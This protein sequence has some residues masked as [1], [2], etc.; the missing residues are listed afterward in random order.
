[1]TIP[2]VL[3]FGACAMGG[4]AIVAR[5]LAAWLPTVGMLDAPATG[6]QDRSV[7]RG[8]GV[9]IVAPVLLLGCLLLPNDP[10]SRQRIVV[11]VTAAG[12]I[13]IVS[14]IDDIR[15]IAVSIRLATH[16]ALA[17]ATIATVGPIR[18]ISAGPLGTLPLGAAAWPLSMLWIVGLTNAFNF[19]DG[20]DAMAGITAAVAGGAVAV[21]SW[22]V[23]EPRV[24]AVAIV[25]A[26]AC[27]GFLTVNWPPARIFMGDVGST[28]CGFLLAT[29]PMMATAGGEP[30]LALIVLLTTSPFLLDTA[31]TLSRRISHGE[32]IFQSHRTH[33]YQQLVLAGWPQA[34]VS[35][36]YG[37]LAAAAGAF[38]IYMTL[39]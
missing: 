35:C 27:L 7:P 6:F 22:L 16:V 2:G 18:E 4:A 37:G 13:A 23:G 19:M 1:M 3:L 11:P 5:A 29:L 30:R 12:G 25:F 39:R 31:L 26:A 20:I 33:I 17:A 9:A 24:G 10:A 15:T 38:G 14:L 28:F 34:T 8:G 36:L 21:A 32:N